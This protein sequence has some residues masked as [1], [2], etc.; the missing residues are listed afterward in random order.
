[1]LILQTRH[2][3]MVI[4]GVL[5]L[6]AATVDT[7]AHTLGEFALEFGIGATLAAA[8]IIFCWFFGQRNYLAYA[9]VLWLGMLAS[10]A[11]QLMG[12]ARQWHAWAIVVV[13]VVSVLW[14]IWPAFT[15][16]RD[17]V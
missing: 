1:M 5:V 13:M 9:L 7:D 3:W 12:T 10:P 11:A 15:R 4:S 17:G 14:A 16:R 6:I 8:L 2:R